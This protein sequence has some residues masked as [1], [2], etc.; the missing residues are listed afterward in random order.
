MGQFATEAK[1]NTINKAIIN[2]EKRL[3]EI[4]SKLYLQYNNIIHS[5]SLTITKVYQIIEL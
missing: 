3:T 2:I 4:E 1:F 5:N